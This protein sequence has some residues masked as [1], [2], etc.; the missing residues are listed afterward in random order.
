MCCFVYRK[1]CGNQTKYNSSPR[2]APLPRPTPYQVS[3][4]KSNGEDS[5]ATIQK[6]DGKKN[7][8]LYY[9]GPIIYSTF[10]TNYLSIFQ[11][12]V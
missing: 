2:H 8:I 5:K 12:L 6:I 10:S 7:S 3:F 11:S 9:F 4:K 1:L